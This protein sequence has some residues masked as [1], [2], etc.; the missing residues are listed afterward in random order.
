VK[1]ETAMPRKRET[2]TKED[3]ITL[4]Q[5]MGNGGAVTF[6]GETYTCNAEELRVAT[7]VADE[8][9][10]AFLTALTSAYHCVLQVELEHPSTLPRPAT[11]AARALYAWSK[12]DLTSMDL[13]ARAL[14]LL[15]G[16]R[17]Q[18][19]H[20]FDYSRVPNVAFPIV[21]ELQH[22]IDFAIIS[23]CEHLAAIVD[24]CAMCD[25]V[26]VLDADRL[27]HS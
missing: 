16:L 10:I 6:H 7:K 26:V 1:K 8:K 23:A 17:T 12:I 18:I 14:T 24:D 2:Y 27:A 3:V 9:R 4:L 21:K 11:V 5:I 15:P 25:M 13:I 19:V 22:K 20:G